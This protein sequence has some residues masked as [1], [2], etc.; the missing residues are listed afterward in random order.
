MDFMDFNFG[1]R[2]V[3]ERFVGLSANEQ[4]Q[5][6]QSLSRDDRYSLVCWA[7]Q[8]KRE[9]KA[10]ERKAK[11]QCKKLAIQAAIDDVV[12]HILLGVPLPGDQA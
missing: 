5:L 1:D 10:A 6:W 7:E 9:H 2:R 11:R 3:A 8:Q 12:E 4:Q